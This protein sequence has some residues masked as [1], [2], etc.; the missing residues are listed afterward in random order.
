MCL[1]SSEYLMMQHRL[2]VMDVDFKSLKRKKRSFGDFRLTLWNL[3]RDNAIKLADKI[4][5][6]GNANQMWGDMAKCI[7]RSP[8]KNLRVSKGGSARMKRA[9]W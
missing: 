9:W 3:T 5:V 4:K 2:S 6:A 1:I 8:K 7:Q